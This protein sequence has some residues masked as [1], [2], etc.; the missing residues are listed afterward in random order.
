MPKILDVKVDC[1]DLELA[2]QRIESYLESSTLDYVVTVNP[3]FLV[4]AQKDKHFKQII[5][6]SSLS[7]AD[8]VGISLVAGRGLQR[9][10]GVDLVWKLADALA[11]TSRRLFL[12]GGR[13]GVA[14]KAAERIK[15][16]FPSLDIVGVLDGVDASADKNIQIINKAEPDVLLVGLGAGKQEKWIVKNASFLGSCRVALGVGGT[17]DMIAG[18]LPR[19]PYFFRYLGLEWLW[20]LYLEPKRLP[21]IYSVVVV[22]PW[23]V[24]RDKI[25]TK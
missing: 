15:A 11:S 3:E 9:A 16:K 13:K 25:S 2:V 7:T 19:A 12:F 23:L 10:P 5:N 1:F 18:R 8:G 4:K 22:F 17:F 20:R 14:Q 6:E 21:R 24:F